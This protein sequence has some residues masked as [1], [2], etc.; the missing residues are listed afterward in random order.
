VVSLCVLLKLVKYYRRF[1]RLIKINDLK[2][3]L[4]NSAVINWDFPPVFSPFINKL[5]GK[6]IEPAMRGEEARSASF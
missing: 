3:K 5:A 6:T 1:E 4:L 2:I